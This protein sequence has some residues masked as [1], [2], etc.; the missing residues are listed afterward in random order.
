[1]SDLY[2]TLRAIVRDELRSLRLGDLAVVTA[3]HPH[4]EGDANNHACDVKL[5]EGGLTLKNVPIATPHTG[6]VSAPRK[7]DLVILS[8]LGGDPE[9]PVIVGR[10]YSDKY[11]PPVHEEGELHIVSGPAGETSIVF[12]KDESVV[13]RAGETV[14]TIRKGD[15][16]TIEGPKDLEIEVKGNAVIAC[17]DCKVD[18]KGDIELGSGGGGVITTAS[19]KCYFTGAPLVGSKTVKAKG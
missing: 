19:H 11:T 5:R 17:Q 6:M 13:I 8:Y 12:D 18:A 2:A 15:A 1:M 3:A 7:D 10:L 16:I 9:R 14:V 4:A